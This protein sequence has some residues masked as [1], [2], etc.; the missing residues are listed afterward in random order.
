MRSAVTE[1]ESSCAVTWFRMHSRENFPT[2][3][4]HLPTVLLCSSFSTLEALCLYLLVT[5]IQ[6]VPSSA[7]EVWHREHNTEECVSIDIAAP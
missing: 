7:L 1:Q 5:G 3:L 4:S 2:Y 6:E